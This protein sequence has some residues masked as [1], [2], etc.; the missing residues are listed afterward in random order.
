MEQLFIVRSY[1]K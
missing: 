1:W